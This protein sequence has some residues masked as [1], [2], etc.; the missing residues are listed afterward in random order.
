VKKSPG[1]RKRASPTV[2]HAAKSSDSKQAASAATPGAPTNSSENAS[3]CLY[4]VLGVARDASAKDISRAYRRLALEWHPDKQAGRAAASSTSELDQAVEFAK[5]R[6]QVLQ[7]AYDVLKDPEKRAHYDQYGTTGNDLLD[8][9]QN[10]KQYFG[11]RLKAEDIDSFINSYYGSSEEREDIRKIVEDGKIQSLFAYLIGSESR[12]AE[13]YLKVIK[14]IKEEMGVEFGA[15][16][17]KAFKVYVQ[18]TRKQEQGR[19]KRFEKAQR[20][21]EAEDSLDLIAAIQKRNR[22]P[23]N[24]N[25]VLAAA[26]RESEE[27][28]QRKAKKRKT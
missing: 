1:A 22:L 21:N 6:F 3:D 18:K 9:E 11:P 28:E 12:H 2:Q 15:A 14:E 4:D 7:E 25:G 24:P 19:R 20:G 8:Q 27:G 10:F 23:I 26:M 16:E 17:E 5:K 13:R